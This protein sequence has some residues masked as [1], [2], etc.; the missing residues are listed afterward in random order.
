MLWSISGA[1]LIAASALV[2]HLPDEPDDKYGQTDDHESERIQVRRYPVPFILLQV[3]RKL[4]SDGSFILP[5]A[6][7]ISRSTVAQH[8][9]EEVSMAFHPTCIVWWQRPES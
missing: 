4:L 7:R 1:D 6:D 9:I 2:S 3:N 8:S 5:S